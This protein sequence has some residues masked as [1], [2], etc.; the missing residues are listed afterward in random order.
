MS[1]LISRRAAIDAL[2][3]ALYEYE[4]KTKKQFQESEDLDV[5]DWIEHR[6]FVQNMNDIDRQVILNM[7]SAQPKQQWI[8][9]SKSLPD[10][11]GK[12]LVTAFDG[13]KNRTTYVQY[14]KKTKSWVLTGTRAYWK[15]LAWAHLPE[16][17]R[18][19]SNDRS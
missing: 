2:W 1:D 9:V 8:P 12:Y 14:Q 18:G 10:E 17:W 3:D 13:H 11:S 7:P 19:E 6:I 5:E 15:V 16:P 4:D